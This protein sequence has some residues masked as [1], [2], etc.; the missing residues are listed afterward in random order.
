[1]LRYEIMFDFL[2]G[3]P[4]RLDT[5]PNPDS[6][7]K[8]LVYASLGCWGCMHM[9]RWKSWG[10]SRSAKAITSLEGP[11]RHLH[12]F[13]RRQDGKEA[14][15]V[16]LLAPPLTRSTLSRCLLGGQVRKSLRATGSC[17]PSWSAWFFY[18]FRKSSE[19]KPLFSQLIAG[20]AFKEKK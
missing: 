2:P 17:P 19:I 18:P 8:L 13:G 5:A 16:C 3:W 12:F 9:L 4:V 7:S 20:L 10:L 14:S 15:C 11:P 6:I 1:M